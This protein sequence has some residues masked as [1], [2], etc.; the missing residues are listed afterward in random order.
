MTKDI[1]QLLHE[2]KDDLNIFHSLR[3]EDLDTL[4]PYFNILHYPAGST[5]FKEGDSG[6]FMGFV[7]SGRLEVKKK[8]ELK[9]RQVV[10]ALL[11]KGSF[12]G[13]LS[14]ID[15]H[16]RSAN[17]TAAEDSFLLI[18]KKSSFDSFLESY[19]SIGIQILKGI[20]RILSIRLRKSVDRLAELF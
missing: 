7:I 16:P 17:V 8:T 18:L 1:K 3:V 10:L 5:I 2:M 14:L 20:N 15:G 9:G 4:A 13:E 12:V 19:P 11:S 6:D